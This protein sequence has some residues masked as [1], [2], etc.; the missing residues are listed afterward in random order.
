M[1]SP[2]LWHHP[3]DFL[4]ASHLARP[5]TAPPH[6]LA[7][8]ALLSTHHISRPAAQSAAPPNLLVFDID[9][10]QPRD[11]GSR[12]PLLAIRCRWRRDWSVDG[13]MLLVLFDDFG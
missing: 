1:R 8:V 3:L 9:R 5:T 2:V 6:L 13:G 10:L 7:A 11:A 12:A 4:R